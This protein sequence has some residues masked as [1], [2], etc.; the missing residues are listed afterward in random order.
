MFRCLTGHPFVLGVSVVLSLVVMSVS[1]VYIYALCGLRA[2]FPVGD[3]FPMLVLYIY[4]DVSLFSVARSALLVICSVYICC[5][6]FPPF[7]ILFFHHA[8]LHALWHFLF[9]LFFFQPGSVRGGRCPPRYINWEWGSG[10]WG[11]GLGKVCLITPKCD[12][13]TNIGK[14]TAWFFFPFSA[15]AVFVLPHKQILFH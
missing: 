14:G 15:L 12:Y 7:S 1:V 9:L 2:F 4:I 5:T 10:E 6:Q 13:H 11:S 3:A 8:Y